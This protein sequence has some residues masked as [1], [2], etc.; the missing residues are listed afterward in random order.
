MSKS[1]NLEDAM[2]RPNIP[3]AWVGEEV[4]IEISER[5]P[6]KP[7]RSGPAFHTEV[8]RLRDINQ[9]GV[10]LETTSYGGGELNKEFYP[11]NSIRRIILLSTKPP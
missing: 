10:A 1:T 3:E 9:F 2:E 11:W 7:S 8:G 4:R 5:L 6:E